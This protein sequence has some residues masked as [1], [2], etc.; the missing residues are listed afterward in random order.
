MQ[1]PVSNTKKR[2]NVSSHRSVV[3]SD[4]DFVYHY[5]QN[6]CYGLRLV[7]NG[8]ARWLLRERHRQQ[9]PA[10]AKQ[11]F[12]CVSAEREFEIAVDYSVTSS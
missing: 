10:A 11:V 6:E 8:T 3:D 5:I 12:C 2:K 9:P 4:A 7:V 1:N